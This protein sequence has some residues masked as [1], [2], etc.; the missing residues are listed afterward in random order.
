MIPT[1]TFISVC[2]V[3]TILSGLYLFSIYEICRTIKD[4][5][6]YPR[7]DIIPTSLLATVVWFAVL[8]LGN[9]IIGETTKEI[10]LILILT[11][12]L[13]NGIINILYCI[14]LGK[15]EKRYVNILKKRGKENSWSKKSLFYK[16]YDKLDFRRIE[17]WLMGSEDWNIRLGI[18]LKIQ[19]KKGIFL[20]FIVSSIIIPTLAAIIFFIIFYGTRNMIFPVLLLY[21][22][23]FIIGFKTI[24]ALFFLFRTTYQSHSIH[25]TWDKISPDSDKQLVFQE[26]RRK[27]LNYKPFF[28]VPWEV[29]FWIAGVIIAYA[30]FKNNSELMHNLKN[31]LFYSGIIMGVPYLLQVLCANITGAGWRIESDSQ[32]EKLID[33][34]IEHRKKWPWPKM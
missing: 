5:R 19:A 25:K 7:H 21:I 33:C 22:C 1:V 4:K 16:L 26:I 2:V 8:I 14:H 24:Y 13:Y 31:I 11:Q 20:K 10:L 28:W 6:K 29:L 17:N 18:Y 32:L 30:F 15:R 9:I 34:Y 12:I 3:L 23:L 27:E